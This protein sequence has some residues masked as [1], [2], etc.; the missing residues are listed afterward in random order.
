MADSWAP[1]EEAQPTPTATAAI[2]DTKPAGWVDQQTNDYSSDAPGIVTQAWDGS[3][4][5]YEWSDEFGDVGPKLP[6]LEMEL[7]GDSSTRP[8]RS[9]GLDFST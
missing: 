3:A 1:T 6:E 2:Q 7:F 8:E 5:V 9:T 4:R